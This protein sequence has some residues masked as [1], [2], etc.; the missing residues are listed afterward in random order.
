MKVIAKEGLVA[1]AEMEGVSR[2]VSL[3]ILDD[4]HIGDYILVHAGFA[5]EKVDEK[6]AHETLKLMQELSR[7]EETL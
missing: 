5:I 7:L 2:E 6:E 3:R 1:T 4:V